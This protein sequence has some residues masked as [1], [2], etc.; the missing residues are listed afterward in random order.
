MLQS[1]ITDP[2]SAHG[3]RL[4]G[5]VTLSDAA[6]SQAIL[7]RF[8]EARKQVAK[9]DLLPAS[10]GDLVAGV[11]PGAPPHGSRR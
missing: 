1:L 2:L 5:V 3:Y 8:V 9:A 6:S 11:V 4:D 10:K 7:D